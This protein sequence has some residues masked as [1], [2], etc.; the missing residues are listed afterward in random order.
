MFVEDTKLF[1]IGFN[2]D[3]TSFYVDNIRLEKKEEAIEEQ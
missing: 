2:D 1:A 3:K